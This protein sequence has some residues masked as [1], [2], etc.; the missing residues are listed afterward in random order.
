VEERKT[1]H[2]P[3]DEE[4]ILKLLA[5]YMHTR[6][7]TW[8]DPRARVYF[9]DPGDRTAVRVTLQKPSVDHVV[10]FT[11]YCDWS[12]FIQ[13]TLKAKVEV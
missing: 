8:F 13:S 10:L 12:M 3:R 7:T 5:P 9:G 1:L 4:E 6:K 11:D 2:W